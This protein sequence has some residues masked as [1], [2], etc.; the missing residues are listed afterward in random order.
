MS[1]DEDAAEVAM[2]LDDLQSRERFA[3]THF[4]VP[5]HLI[6]FLEL[7]ERLVDSLALFG[8]EPDG[9][10]P[11]S[12]LRA[13]QGF[14]ALLDSGDGSLGSFEVATEPLVG[15][16]DLVE[17]FPFDATAQQYL[18]DFLVIDGGNSAIAH[19]NCNFR[20][21]EFIS[22]AGGLGVLV[23]T[24]LGR[25]V[26]RTAVRRQCNVAVLKSGFANFQAVAMCRVR[27]AEHIYQLGFKI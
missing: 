10:L 3:E 21:E 25:F 19:E 5:E 9:R 13:F 6:A 17:N 2:F 23:D 18:V 26:K 16:V 1:E 7:L 8:A 22:D 27:Y 11:D 12:N 20:V 24:S 14:A 15:T 4:G